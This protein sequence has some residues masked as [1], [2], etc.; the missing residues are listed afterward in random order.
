[1]DSRD[2]V[3]FDRLKDRI[4]SGALSDTVAISHGQPRIQVA[5]VR[6]VEAQ[7]RLG[8]PTIYVIIN[9]WRNQFVL[10]KISVAARKRQGQ[11]LLS[12][13]VSMRLSLSKLMVGASANLSLN[14]AGR[15]LCGVL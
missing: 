8:G 4:S 9:S 10:T 2:A 12:A 6:T 15:K 3:P 1:M 14:Q 5:V 7:Q 11:A 13:C